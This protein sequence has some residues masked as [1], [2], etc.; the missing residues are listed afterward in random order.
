MKRFSNV[1][2][3]LEFAQ[4]YTSGKFTEFSAR[5]AQ[6]L[7]SILDQYQMKPKTILDVACGEGTFAIAMAK[8]G[9]NVT[10]IDQSPEMLKIARK[11]AQAEGV[12]ITLHEMDMRHLKLKTTFDMVTC[13]FDSLNYLLTNDDLASTFTGIA[14]H[15]N[16]RGHFIFDMNT[17]YWLTTLANR[18][19]VTLERETENIFQVHR[20]SYDE[21]TR[22]ATFEITGFIKDDGCWQRQVDET[23]HERGYTIDEIRSCLKNAGMTEIACSGNLEE[24]LPYSSES[25]RVWFIAKK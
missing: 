15:L 2:V 19:A 9:F 20:H 22:I 12:T 16:P 11:K 17:I 14:K 25:K 1:K 10:G 7:P 21:K 23:H 13:W 3:Y 6:L 5:M 18:Y 24:G 8:A 4:L